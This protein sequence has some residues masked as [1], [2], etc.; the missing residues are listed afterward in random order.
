MVE[1]YRQGKTELLDTKTHCISITSSN[2]LMI[3]IEKITLYNIQQ[4]K[5]SYTETFWKTNEY[6]KIKNS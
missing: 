4:N 6:N 1:C 5:W 2:V 3:I